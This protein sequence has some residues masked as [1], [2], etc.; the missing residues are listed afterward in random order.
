MKLSLNFPP[1][2]SDGGKPV[3]ARPAKVGPWL[4]GIGKRDTVTAA[5]L[6]GDAVA[7]T[8]RTAISDARR[9]ELAT[10]YWKAS[11]ELWTPLL[12]RFAKAPQPLTGDAQLAA[13][14][15]LVLATELSAMWKRLLAREADKRLSLGGQRLL[16]PVRRALQSRAVCNSYAP[17][18]VPG[19]RARMH[20]T[21]MYG[22]E[23]VHQNTLGPSD[24]RTPR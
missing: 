6:F 10:I 21:Y 9:M 16:R 11:T 13:R 14:T 19:S 1:L 23:Q 7:A 3:E 2:E 15:S 18:A 4:E 5:R 24:R 12:K 8:N 17:T 22:P 20:A